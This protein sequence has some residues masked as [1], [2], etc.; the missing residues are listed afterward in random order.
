MVSDVFRGGRFLPCSCRLGWVWLAAREVLLAQRLYNAGLIRSPE[1]MG[2]VDEDW[3]RTYGSEHMYR[4][5]AQWVAENCGEADRLCVRQCRPRGTPTATAVTPDIVRQQ[6]SEIQEILVSAGIA[7]G[8]PPRIVKP[9]LVW[10][11]DE[12]GYS[13]RGVS[14]PRAVVTKAQGRWA[15]S[16]VG[17]PDFEHISVLGF[18]SLAGAHT[19]PSCFF[20]YVLSHAWKCG[21]V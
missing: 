7:E 16:A 5:F 21:F 14:K 2:R 12:K 10:C 6:L 20:I 11:C 18:A 9:S 4:D 3:A 15:T 17:D 8:L 13:A 1:E 19:G